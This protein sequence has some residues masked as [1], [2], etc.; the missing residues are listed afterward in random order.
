MKLRI[1]GNTIR[2]RLTKSEVAYFSEKK[3][4]Q[5]ST[6]LGLKDFSYGLKISEEAQKIGA[7]Y[8]NDAIIVTIPTA[9]AK[10]WTETNQVGLSEEMPLQD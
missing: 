6:N 10:S 7:E 5:E 1:K 8:V 3:L 4:I 9:L 2:F